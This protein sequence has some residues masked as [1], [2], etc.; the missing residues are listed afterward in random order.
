MAQSV[1]TAHATATVV[2]CG[3]IW[4]VQV[5][6][7]P[8]FALVGREAF[9]GYER[10]HVRR[11]GWIVGPPMIVEG[12]TAVWLLASAPAGIG[13]QIPGVGFALLVLIWCATAM[14]Q[15]P[16][17]RRLESGFAEVTHRRLVRTNWIRTILWTVRAALALWML[18]SAA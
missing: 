12:I 2:M 14:V 11:T 13:R 3:L 7:Y 17:H 10:E 1:L 15:V 18:S 4:F 5:V 9:A 6:H 16:A 8:L